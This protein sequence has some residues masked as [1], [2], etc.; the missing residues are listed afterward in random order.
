MDLQLAGRTAIVTG[1]SSGIG[2]A[3]VKELL[4]EGA[5]VYTCARDDERLTAALAPLAQER[6]VGQACDVLDEPAVT[7]FVE[8]AAA[9]TG[10]I[11]VLVCNAGQGRTS[12]FATTTR[13]DWHEE[14]DLKIASVANAV[15]PARAHLERAGGAVV[16]VN[17]VLG[18]QPEPHMVAT[19][20]A[21][22]AVLNLAR[23]LARELAPAVRVNSVLLGLVRSEQ[24]HR[25]WQQ[26]GSELGEEEW[27]ARL[28]HEKGI[29]LGRV[30]EPAEVAAVIAFLASPRAAFTTGA[31]VEID[32]G[33]ARYS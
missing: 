11:D 10:R 4:A 25:R 14:L 30:G 29:P 31:A 19:S 22:A 8:R 18:R 6:L 24:W 27:L 23:S 16:I 3:T 5:T 26:S 13:A 32:G 21:R 17:A 33:V 1:G 28:A 15:R 7:A 12:T 9:E 2:L 20:A